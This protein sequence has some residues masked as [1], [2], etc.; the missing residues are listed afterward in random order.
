[1][2]RAWIALVLVSCATP[3][4]YDEGPPEPCTDARDGAPLPCAEGLPCWLDVPAS[5]APDGECYQADE[6]EPWLCCPVEGPRCVP[7][8]TCGPGE[9]CDA[10][11]GKGYCSDEGDACCAP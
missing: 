6:H 2:N 7:V 1:M 11:L 5:R 8:F 3:A 4:T 10:G 9:T